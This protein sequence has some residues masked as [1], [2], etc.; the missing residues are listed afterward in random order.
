MGR[1]AGSKQRD[2]LFHVMT[3]LG[4]ARRRGL[5]F[6][7][8]LRP[9]SGVAIATGPDTTDGSVNSSSAASRCCRICSRRLDSSLI[10]FC[11]VARVNMHAIVIGTPWPVKEGST[12]ASCMAFQSDTKFQIRKDLGLSTRTMHPSRHPCTSFSPTPGRF[13]GIMTPAL[14]YFVRLRWD[15]AGSSRPYLSSSD[16]E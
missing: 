6:G 10:S 13:L 4:R 12:R 5:R 14:V 8:G 15:C 2:D 3:A 1:F 11:K 16:F 7:L 9:G